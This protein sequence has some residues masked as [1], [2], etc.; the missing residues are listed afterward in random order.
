M[1][2]LWFSVFLGH[3]CW[4]S[5]ASIYHNTKELCSESEFPCSGPAG[6][7]SCSLLPCTEHSCKVIKNTYITTL[8][9][10]LQ[11]TLVWKKLS[12]KYTESHW[13]EGTHLLTFHSLLTQPAHTRAAQRWLVVLWRFAMSGQPWLKDFFTTLQLHNTFDQTFIILIYMYNMYVSTYLLQ[14]CLEALV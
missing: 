6:P 12:Q 10:P 7:L 5:T 4:L 9:V 8:F 13:S 11:L 14:Q 2:I 3:H 1:K